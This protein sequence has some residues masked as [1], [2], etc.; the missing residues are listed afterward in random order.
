M[1]YAKNDFD[2]SQQ[3]IEML[4]R[5]VS[6]FPRGSRASSSQT[7]SDSSFSKIQDSMMKVGLV[8]GTFTG[9]Y[10][11][12]EELERCSEGNIYKFVIAMTY[13]TA[14]AVVGFSLGLVYPSVLM[15]GVIY[16]A[17]KIGKKLSE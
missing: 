7:S 9:S 11:A 12:F 4:T 5:F 3:E 14:G 8:S 17:H 10:L 6:R 13:P 1:Y 16:G 15:G 2:F